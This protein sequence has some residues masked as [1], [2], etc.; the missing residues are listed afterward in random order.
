MTIRA[1]FQPRRGTNQVLTP[2]AASASTPIDPEAKSVRLVNSGTTNICHVRIGE[3][4][5]TATV[6]DLP[7]LPGESI[8][9]QKGEGEDTLAHISASGTTLHVQTGEGGV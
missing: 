5:Q 6:A 2:A 4:A 9:V 3:G 1:P 8:I 7:V